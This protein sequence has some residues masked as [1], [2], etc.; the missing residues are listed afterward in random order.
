MWSMGLTHLAFAM[1][2]VGTSSES[3]PFIVEEEKLEFGSEI[4]SPEKRQRPRDGMG[5]FSRQG[6]TNQ[7][8]RKFSPKWS[9]KQLQSCI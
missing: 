8:N 9:Y 2:K 5:T 4:P 1:K 6:T 3:W 7:F